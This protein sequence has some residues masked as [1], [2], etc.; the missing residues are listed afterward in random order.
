MRSRSATNRHLEALGLNSNHLARSNNLDCADRRLDQCHEILKG[1]AHAAED[2]Y[3]Q[4]AS[5]EILL[6]LRISISRKEDVETSGFS[7]IEQL[8]ILESSPR[9]LMDSSNLV[10]GQQ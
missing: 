8:P 4:L 2:H 9:L 3:S 10:A 7:R 5:D 6:K 1:V